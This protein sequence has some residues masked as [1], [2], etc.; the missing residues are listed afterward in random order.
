V[1][2][3]HHA[4]R[5]N[6]RYLAR[7]EQSV[8][9]NAASLRPPDQTKARASLWL[10][11]LLAA[12]LLAA[13]IHTIQH[14]GNSTPYW[15]QWD[16]EAARLYKP[17]LEGELSVGHLI[18]PHNEHRIFTT[19]LVHLVLF[20]ALGQRWEPLVQMYGNAA[21]HV[22]AIVLLV[23]FA[24]SAVPNR[25]RALLG[26]FA[27]LL[28]LVPF[29]WDST[30]QGFNTHFYFVLLGG[31]VL[32]LLCVGGDFTP[33]KAVWAFV[34]SACLALTMAS[35]AL[36][37]SAAAGV[38]AFRRFVL[39]DRH[40]PLG[41]MVL[42]GGIAIL[43]IALTPH[44]PGHAHLKAQSLPQL[45]V[46]VGRTWAWPFAPERLTAFHAAIPVIMQAPLFLGIVVASRSPEAQRSLLFLVAMGTWFM[47]QTLALGYGR[48]ADVLTSRYLDTLSFG[49][50]V[51]FAALLILWSRTTTGWQPALA[52]LTGCWL[53]VVIY[54]IHRAVPDLQR[55]LQAKALT[56]QVQE[57]NVRGYLLTSDERFLREVDFLKIPYPSGERLQQ[58][59]DDPTI[60]KVLPPDLWQPRS[61]ETMDNPHLVPVY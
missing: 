45:A 49:L 60:R 50:L 46:A 56:S 4:E 34:L 19:R 22:A 61:R 24:G 6:R 25:F 47:L 1:E 26:I 10:L 9:M 27:A 5:E 54:S 21:L 55:E 48:A 37:V 53:G 33:T 41:V 40:V 8:E 28:F 31:V 57:F 13:K 38:L 23:V 32:L 59:L 3:T 43:G 20:E 14:Y 12:V 51:N 44:I 58:L 11:V 30:L 16:A 42:L 39:L 35:G 17:W 2:E 7:D 29:G 52:L 15:D 36:A 18:E